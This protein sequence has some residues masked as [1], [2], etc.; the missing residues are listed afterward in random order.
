MNRIDGMPTEFEW[1]IFLEKIQNLMRDLQC[2]AEHF[3][4]RIIF[5]SM[6]NET[7]HGMNKEIKKDVNTIHQKF[8]IVLVNFFAVIGL[9]W[10]WI[11]RKVVRNLH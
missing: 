7:L 3:K 6:Y 2:E 1:N 5:M 4:D 9:F 10:A 11:R 8:R